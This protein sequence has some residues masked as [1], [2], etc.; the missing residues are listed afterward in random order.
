MAVKLRL[1]RMG[2][3]KRPVYALVAADAR[4]PRDG[5]FI[6]D[7]GRYEPLNGSDLTKID[8][9]RVIY[10]LGQG[11]QPS[12]TVRDL[13]S[14]EGILLR[15]HLGFKGKSEEEIAEAVEAHRAAR[16][17]KSGQ[18]MTASDRAR[19]ALEAERKKA[20][21]EAKIRAE[22]E[23]K[24]EEAK[25]QAAEQIKQQE[26]AEEAAAEGDTTVEASA[27]EVPESAPEAAADQPVVEASEGEDI[28]AEE[29]Q[30]AV[31]AADE[32][33][34]QAAEAAADDSSSDEAK[35]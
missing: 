30:A 24:A 12:D 35:A 4:A 14:R 25:R 27:D 5:K 18:T 7:L 33:Q 8:A 3:K 15:R 11:A 20:A 13:L 19:A 16:A 22:E 23:R 34:K 31:D 21:E 6:E 1:R 26:T 32:A 17:E 29:A 28:P 9:D 10:W 2:R